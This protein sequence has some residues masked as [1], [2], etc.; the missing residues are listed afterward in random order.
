MNTKKDGYQFINNIIY[1]QIQFSKIELQNGNN[2]LNKYDITNLNKIISL[3]IHDGGYLKKE[4]PNT[5]FDHH[6]MMKF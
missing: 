3:N 1:N 4:F 6:A 5:N 2:F